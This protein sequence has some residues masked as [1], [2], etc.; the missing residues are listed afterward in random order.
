MKYLFSLKH[1][2]FAFTLKHIF[3]EYPRLVVIFSNH[4]KDDIP[5]LL[6]S[7]IYVKKSVVRVI[8]ALLSVMS[9]FSLAVFKKFS[10][11]LIFRSLSRMCL[12]MISFIFILL[13]ACST[14]WILG[15]K[16]INFENS[17]S[18]FLQIILLLLNFWNYKFQNLSP[19]SWLCLFS[20]I[21]CFNLIFFSTDPASSKIILSSVSSIMLLNHVL[22]FYLTLFLQW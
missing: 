13:A 8:V 22:S 16:F 10:L 17:R 6:A 2:Y 4:F 18:L 20:F 9:L 14:S 3:N 7:T 11:F 5:C 1:L 12:G 15:L 21:L 19:Y